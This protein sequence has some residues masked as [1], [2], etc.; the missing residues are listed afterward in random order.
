MQAL[1]VTDEK[2]TVNHSWE[3]LL[4]YSVETKIKSKTTGNSRI[5]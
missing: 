1:Y 2:L 4:F 3:N 5:I